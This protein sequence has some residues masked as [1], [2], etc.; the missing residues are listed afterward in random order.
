MRRL[1]GES[2]FFKFENRASLCS[3]GVHSNQSGR[4]LSLVVG[5][6]AGV[7]CGHRQKFSLAYYRAIHYKNLQ[8]HT[9]TQQNGFRA[10]E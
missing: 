9:A 4:D 2:Q 8:L 3:S 6:K 1:F 10:H 7:F 5:V